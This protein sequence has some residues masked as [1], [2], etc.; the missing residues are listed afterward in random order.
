[1]LCQ[2]ILRVLLIQFQH[3]AVTADLGQHRGRADAGAGGIALDHR[4]C[5]DLQACGGAVS[6]NQHQIRHDVQLLHRLLHPAHGGVQ[7][8]FPVDDLR[9]HKNDAV[10]QRFFADLI[11]QCF[12]LFLGQLFGIVDAVHRV[13]R[14]QNTGRYANRAAKRAAPGLVHTGKAAVL[15]AHLGI[16]GVQRSRDL[17]IRAALHSSFSSAKSAR[18]SRCGGRSREIRPHLQARNS[19]TSM[20]A[21]R[22]VF[23]S[24][25]RTSSPR[26][27][28]MASSSS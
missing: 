25:P 4:L 24:P 21:Q 9:P 28:P 18:S 11:K 3:I 1:M 10:G 5:R 26:L 17:L 14:V 27:R 23:T 22:S 15:A 16:K 6:V 8:V 20:M 19:S 13:F 7:D 12:T 2:L